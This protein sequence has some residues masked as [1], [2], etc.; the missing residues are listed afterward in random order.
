MAL[1]KSEN[2]TAANTFTLN[3]GTAA[4]RRSTADDEGILWYARSHSQ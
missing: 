1:V 4:G 3:A 2:L